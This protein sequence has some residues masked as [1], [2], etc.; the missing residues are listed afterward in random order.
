MRPPDLL[1]MKRLQIAACAIRKEG[2]VEIKKKFLVSAAEK[3]LRVHQ[4]F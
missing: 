2:G 1:M 3:N 4:H